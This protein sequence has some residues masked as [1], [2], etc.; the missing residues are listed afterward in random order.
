MYL[1]KRTPWK[2]YILY[3]WD[4][5]CIEIIIKLRVQSAISYTI[6]KQEVQDAK[7]PK[8]DFCFQIFVSLIL[9]LP[10]KVMM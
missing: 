8:T 3:L 6:W 7:N 5:S 10:I 9:N 1:H 2:K 4:E